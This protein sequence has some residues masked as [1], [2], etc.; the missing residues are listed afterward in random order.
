[1]CTHLRML[2]IN[3]GLI[4]GLCTDTGDAVSMLCA[5]LP[6]LLVLQWRMAMC[7]P[8]RPNHF[9][10][11]FVLNVASNPN[12][13]GLQLLQA[14]LLP[15]HVQNAEELPHSTVLQQHAACCSLPCQYHC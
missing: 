3:T 13:Q 6:H 14:Y 9:S 2:Y 5:R 12:L 8:E 11:A 4:S 7:G 10:T 1:M 15:S